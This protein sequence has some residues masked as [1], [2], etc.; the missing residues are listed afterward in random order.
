LTAAS[1][2]SSPWSPALAGLRAVAA[3]GLFLAP[4]PVLQRVPVRVVSRIPFFGD[5]RGGF[6]GRRFERFFLVT[7]PFGGDEFLFF[8]FQLLQD[9]FRLRRLVGFRFIEVQVGAEIVLLLRCGTR[10]LRTATGRPFFLRQWLLFGRARGSGTCVLAAAGFG[11]VFCRLRFGGAVRF[12]QGKIFRD[13][14]RIPG[15]VGA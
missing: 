10:G 2:A 5:W 3:L 12:V 11:R 1:P 6:F 4:L 7:G 13:D 9:G 8:D 14:E 15:R